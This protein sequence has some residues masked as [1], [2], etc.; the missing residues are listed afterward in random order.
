MPRSGGDSSKLGNRYEGLWTVR[1]LID[2]LSGDAVA[3][4]PESYDEALGVEFVKML[5]DIISLIGLKTPM[6]WG[7]S[8]LSIGAI[9]GTSKQTLF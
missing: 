4:S 9:S 8:N 7:R 2:V 5:P 3:L 6:R 1:N